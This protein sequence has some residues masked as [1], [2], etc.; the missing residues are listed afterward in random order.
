MKKSQRG[1][2]KKKWRK[3]DRE[4]EYHCRVKTVDWTGIA[5]TGCHIMSLALSAALRRQTTSIYISR[6]KFPLTSPLQ[7]SPA[8][9]PLLSI[10][11]LFL[12]LCILSLTPHSLSLSPCYSVSLSIT[13][14]VNWRLC[15]NEC[16]SI[17][18]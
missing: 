6:T 12:F 5:I 10:S 9:S 15:T 11:L 18:A 2:R 4:K 17:E 8:I 14:P 7:P 13:P 1:K 3:R 16:R